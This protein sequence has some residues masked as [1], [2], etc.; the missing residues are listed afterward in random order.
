MRKLFAITVVLAVALAATAQQPPRPRT[1]KLALREKQRW[2]AA[3]VVLQRVQFSPDGRLLVSASGGGE[4][5]LW[6]LGGEPRG[7]FSGQ[8]SPM[9]NAVFSPSGE[10]LAT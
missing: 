5:A 3:D 10:L 9:F 6:T 8:R 1:R 4:A 7:H 2:Q